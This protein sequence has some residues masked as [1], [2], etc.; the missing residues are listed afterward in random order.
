MTL[1]TYPSMS[2]ICSL[3]SLSLLQ[4]AAVG[5]QRRRLPKLRPTAAMPRSHI[6]HRHAGRV[7]LGAD[8]VVVVR[9]I[10]ADLEIRT[11]TEIEAHQVLEL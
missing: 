1:S 6:P 2:K 5:S 10:P 7:G 11:Q 4:Q 3:H 8:H 9:I